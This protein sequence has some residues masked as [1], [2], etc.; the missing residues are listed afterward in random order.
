MDLAV[1]YC[2]VPFIPAGSQ[3]APYVCKVLITGMA[4]GS[5]PASGRMLAAQRS[6]GTEQRGR[7]RAVVPSCFS[8]AAAHPGPRSSVL[9][10]PLAIALAYFQLGLDYDQARRDPWKRSLETVRS[11]GCAVGYSILEREM[12]TK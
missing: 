3:P 7:W 11:L 9:A 6:G 10:E 12:V 8:P 2:D 1:S 4:L 5:R